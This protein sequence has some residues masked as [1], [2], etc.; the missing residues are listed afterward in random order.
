MTFLKQ[1]LMQDSTALDHSQLVL[2][3]LATER[4]SLQW[5]ISIISTIDISMISII[6]GLACMTTLLI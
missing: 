4:V 5:A 2:S 1:Q 3:L 6:V